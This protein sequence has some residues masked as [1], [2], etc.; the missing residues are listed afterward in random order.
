VAGEQ[1][2]SPH[3][4]RRAAAEIA[5]R[6]D[7]FRRTTREIYLTP[8][9]Q[10]LPDVDG[11]V[12]AVRTFDDFNPNNDPHG[13]HNFGVFTWHEQDTLWQID[14]FDQTLSYAED[15]LLPECRRVLTLLLSSE[16]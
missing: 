9:I 16:Y 7:E 4:R 10:A 11:L 1:S 15:P 6:N 5:R 12:G 2:S 13:E 3:E 14:Y 8:G